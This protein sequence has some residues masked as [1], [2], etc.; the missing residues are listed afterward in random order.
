MVTSARK[1]PGITPEIAL[2]RHLLAPVR[3]PAGFWRLFDDL[4]EA[5]Q[6]QARRRFRLWRDNHGHPSLRFKRVHPVEPIWSVRITR[7]HRALGL[8]DPDGMVWF[9]IGDHTSYDRMLDRS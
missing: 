9:W 7:D 6:A 4:P 3:R 1:I 8:R 5:V 2:H